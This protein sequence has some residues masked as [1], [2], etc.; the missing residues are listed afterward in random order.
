MKLYFIVVVSKCVLKIKAQEY[1]SRHIVDCTR[2][3]KKSVKS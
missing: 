1:K 3:R 2:G